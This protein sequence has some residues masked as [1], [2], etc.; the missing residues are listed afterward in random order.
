MPLPYFFVV[1]LCK[2]WYNILT[3][4]QKLGERMRDMWTKQ[5]IFKPT[6][7]EYFKTKH[8]IAT[9][10][11]LIPMILFYLIIAFGGADRYNWWMMVGFLGC[12]IFGVGAAYTFAFKRKIY[13]KAL[14]PV[15]CLLFG[16]VLIATSLII[17]F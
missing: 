9:A 16:G 15:L 11:I 6:K 3:H 12:L 10:S 5:Y 1:I 17:L 8:P 13:E 7:E 2:L 14:F 4:K